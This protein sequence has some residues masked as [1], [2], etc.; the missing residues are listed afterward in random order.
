MAIK[1]IKNTMIEPIQMEC[2]SCKSIFEYNFEDIEV[3]EV[4]S[5]FSWIPDHPVRVV[6]C[7]VCKIANTLSESNCSRIMNAIHKGS[8]RS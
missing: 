6:V 1:I 8:H 3:R 4:S 7:P 5:I 2:S